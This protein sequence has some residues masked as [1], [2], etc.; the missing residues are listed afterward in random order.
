M[1]KVDAFIRSSL[2]QL[3]AGGSGRMPGTR[4]GLACLHCLLLPRPQGLCSIADQPGGGQGAHVTPVWTACPLTLAPGPVS[5][6][7]AH[8]RLLDGSPG[9][10]GHLMAWAR[11]ERPLLSD[12]EEAGREHSLLVSPRVCARARGQGRACPAPD[13]SRG[14]S[15]PQD[16]VFDPSLRPCR[17][18]RPGNQSPSPPGRVALP[19]LGRPGHHPR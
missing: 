11:R 15:P 8:P 3:S 13:L 6:T 17:S 12:S 2:N 18:G 14:S 19:H 5:S 4:T 16:S 1:A 10:Q 9:R 7:T